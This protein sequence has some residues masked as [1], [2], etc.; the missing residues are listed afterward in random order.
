MKYQ[1]YLNDSTKI[2]KQRLQ[3]SYRSSRKSK[4]CSFTHQTFACGLLSIF[5]S[6]TSIFRDE[7]E[8]VLVM[9]STVVLS[10]SKKM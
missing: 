6:N 7:K 4:K 8:F 3:Q 10:C 1:I 5:M 2:A 9:Q